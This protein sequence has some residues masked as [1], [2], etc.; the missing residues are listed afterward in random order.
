MRTPGLAACGRMNPLFT[1]PRTGTTLGAST[2]LTLSPLR[3][4]NGRYGHDLAERWA[5]PPMLRARNF[6]FH[7]QFSTVF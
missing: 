6:A 3:M 5:P 7:E 2:S 1:R 4:D